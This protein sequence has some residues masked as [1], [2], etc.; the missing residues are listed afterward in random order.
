MQND[1]NSNKTECAVCDL[2]WGIKWGIIRNEEDIS[3]WEVVPVG[4]C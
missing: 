4:V 3:K 1:S 2:R